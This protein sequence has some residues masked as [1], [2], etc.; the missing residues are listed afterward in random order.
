MGDLA[1]GVLG[2]MAYWFRGHFWLAMIVVLTTRYVGNAAGH[3]YYLVVDHRPTPYNFGIL[4]CA[5]IIVPTLMWALYTVSR[6]NNG[7]ALP[8]GVA[9]PVTVGPN[10]Y[11]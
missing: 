5:D 7:D 6:H 8:K 4:L 3:I 11:A 10:P 2:I 1:I 9:R